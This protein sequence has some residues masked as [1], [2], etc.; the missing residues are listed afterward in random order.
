MNEY[1]TTLSLILLLIIVA[2][3]F[4]ISAMIDVLKK[5]DLKIDILKHEKQELRN[6][7][8]GFDI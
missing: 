7:L 3:M 6:D 5:K 8:T 1:L 4:I 2:Q